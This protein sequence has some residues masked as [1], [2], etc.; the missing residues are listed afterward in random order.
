M[1]GRRRSANVEG[2]RCDGTSGR[3]WEPSPGGKG[4]GGRER[5]TSVYAGLNGGGGGGRRV[6][7][8]PGG[9]KRRGKMWV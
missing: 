2:R 5:G 4:V 7:L 9:R 3:V 8:V 1:R 6:G